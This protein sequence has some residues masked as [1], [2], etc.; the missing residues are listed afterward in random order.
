MGTSRPVMPPMPWPAYRNATDEDLEAM[1]AH[2]RTLAPITNHVPDFQPA[3]E[4][5]DA[6]R[7]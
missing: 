3:A 6:S 2:L 7:D 1:Y 5:S 4:T